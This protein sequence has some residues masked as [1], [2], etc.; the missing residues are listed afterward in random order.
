MTCDERLRVG[1]ADDDHQQTSL[2]RHRDPDVHARLEAQ[3]GRLTVGGLLPLRVDVRVLGQPDRAR[4]GD[5]RVVRQASAVPL[6]ELWGE[7]G[8]EA[9]R[10]GHVHFHQQRHPRHAPR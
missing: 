2:R 3:A 6:L 7:L 9:D 4:L 8:P 5:H 10:L 1:I